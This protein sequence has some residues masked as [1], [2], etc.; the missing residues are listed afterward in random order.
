MVAMDALKCFAIFTV[1]MG[2]CIQYFLSSDYND[3]PG[4]RLIYS[5]HMPLF[6]MITGFFFVKTLRDGF[7]ETMVKKARQLLLPVISWGAIWMFLRM[8]DG[9]S[10]KVIYD[11]WIGNN[12]FWF[13]KSAFICS[14]IGYFVFCNKTANLLIGGIF[15]L[16]ISQ[17]ITRFQIDFMYPCFFAGGLLALKDATCTKVQKLIIPAAVLFIALLIFLNA[18]L[19]KAAKLAQLSAIYKIGAEGIAL[20]LYLIAMGVSGAIFFVAIFNKYLNSNAD[21]K[22]L[23]IISDIGG[24][25]LGIYIIQ[26]IILE[27]ALAKFINFDSFSPLTFNFIIVPLLSIAILIPIY[28]ILRTI[29][30]VPYLSFLLLGTKK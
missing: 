6:M 3:E 26:S 25:T 15:T 20:R 2:H 16:L 9:Q 11:I 30:K 10:W 1:L 24:Y 18:D 21:S 8:C 28:L 7:I 22:V 17:F 27:W 13:L 4:Y 14:L 12:G 5:F 19:Y 29:K 23:H